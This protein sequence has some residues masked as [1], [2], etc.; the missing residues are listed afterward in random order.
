MIVP[1]TLRR[2]GGGQPCCPEQGRRQETPG[3]CRPVRRLRAVIPPRPATLRRRDRHRP[4]TS[5]DPQPKAAPEPTKTIRSHVDSRWSWLISDPVANAPTSQCEK[6][7]QS[8]RKKADAENYLVNCRNSQALPSAHRRSAA[9]RLIPRAAAASWWD[10]AAKVAELHQPSRVGIVAFQPAQRLVQGDEIDGRSFGGGEIFGK[11]NPRPA[12]AV[13][14]GQLGSGLI[15]ED[16]S[17]GLGSR[18]K[19]VAAAVP[20]PGLLEIDETEVCLMHKSRGLECL[21]RPLLG[22]LLGRQVAQLVVNKGHQLLRGTRVTLMDLIQYPRHF[23][24]S[25]HGI[26]PIRSLRFA[27]NPL[28]EKASLSLSLPCTV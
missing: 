20:V 12:A 7:G 15:N 21:T 3:N 13:L 16:A 1:G 23:G 22:Q 19:E 27:R 5:D 6:S 2:I 26:P 24:H 14:L 18:G 10:S 11:V 8:A 28:P 25:V 4:G 9:P 17:H